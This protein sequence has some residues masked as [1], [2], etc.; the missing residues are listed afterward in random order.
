MSAQETPLLADLAARDEQ[1]VA[2]R[3]RI[4]EVDEQAQHAR[5][6]AA[7]IT[8]ELT[9]A[10]AADD[11]AM[12]DKLTRAKAKADA[13]AGEP[14]AERRAGVERAAGRVK[15]ERDTWVTE[16]IGGLL[17][18]LA[19]SAHAAAD[20]IRSTARQLGQARA[21]W[22]SISGRVSALLG[23]VPGVDGRSLPTIEHIDIAIKNALRATADVPAP[24]PVA[25]Q[26][27]TVIAAHDVPAGVRLG[28]DEGVSLDVKEKFARIVAEQARAA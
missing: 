16:N 28:D 25:H 22:H 1:T 19:P 7:R 6:E 18:E 5:S 10:F 23:V 24:L 4:R 26:P 15:A 14:W 3:A 13:K 2:A 12:A 21:D 27:A 8:E 9:E 20:A 11:K 17:D